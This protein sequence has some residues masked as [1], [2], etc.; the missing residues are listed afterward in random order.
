[1]Q[2]RDSYNLK[3]LS[4]EPGGY[5]WR[6]AEGVFNGATYRTSRRTS[7][8]EKNAWVEIRVDTDRRDV[9]EDVTL[10]MNDARA[11]AF[12]RHIL[13]NTDFNVEQADNLIDLILKLCPQNDAQ[14]LSI[15]R[16]VAIVSGLPAISVGWITAVSIAELATRLLLFGGTR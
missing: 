5:E 10:R 15:I 12:V 16:R 7:E 8:D 13:I 14:R 4:G 9:R 11:V 1:M 3:R 6:G 2:E